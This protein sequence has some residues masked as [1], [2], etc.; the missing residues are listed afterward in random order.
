MT[1][2]S[3][4]I[5]KPRRWRGSPKSAVASGTTS[6]AT[7]RLSS[8]SSRIFTLL[9]ALVAYLLSLV[10]AV[11]SRMWGGFQ[12]LLSYFSISSTTTHDGST[13]PG[14]RSNSRLLN[15]PSSNNGEENNRE[16]Y[17][18]NTV[19]VEDPDGRGGNG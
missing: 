7:T 10:W 6:P 19:N 3:A 15:N 14:T 11:P 16:T 5:L 8:R 18:G 17:N 4:L 9:L 12:S 13:S 2:N 1:P